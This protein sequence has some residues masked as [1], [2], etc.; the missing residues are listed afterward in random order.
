M[1]NNKFRQTILQNRN[2]ED[3]YIKNLSHVKFTCD[4]IKYDPT[5]FN[6]T[7]LLNHC[8]LNIE[9]TDYLIDNYFCDVIDVMCRQS[10]SEKHMM[11]ILKSKDKCLC[12]SLTLFQQVPC[13]LLQHY[14]PFM[15]MNIICSCQFL[16][17]QFIV[18]NRDIISWEN[19]FLNFLMQD[20]F[21]ETFL[22]VFKECPIWDHVARSDIPLSTLLKFEEKFTEKTYCDLEEKY[23]CNRS[24]LK[25][26][27]LT[28]EINNMKY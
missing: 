24:E 3:Y 9:T 7:Y 20:I 22:T 28:E 16:D 27:S 1:S 17:L 10:I 12:T 13:R 23:N 6:M 5:I 15:D 18:N 8:V 25:I 4:F 19:L 11:K 26:Y 21:N 14:L 2:C